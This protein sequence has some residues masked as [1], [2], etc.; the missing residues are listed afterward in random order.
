MNAEQ[1]A[2]IAGIILSLAFSYIPKLAEWYAGKDK[3]TKQSIMGALL[4]V[5]A[6]A[7]FGLS[8][9]GL[10]ADL[11]VAVTCDK[12]GAIA[13]LNVLIV[14]LVANQSVYLLTRK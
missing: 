6:V 1:L 11:G 4:I 10:S 9:S 7:A 13:L 14:A 3:Q 5:V 8:C 2:G 12:T